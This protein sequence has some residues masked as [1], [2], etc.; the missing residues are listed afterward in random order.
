MSI[1]K[2]L[3]RTNIS[4][5]SFRP[6]LPIRLN[7]TR[8]LILGLAAQSVISEFAGLA[9]AYVPP[10]LYET[11]T[12][13]SGNLT[14]TTSPNA[15]STT[16]GGTGSTAVP[17][18][19]TVAQFDGNSTSTTSVGAA[20]TWGTWSV[21]NSTATDTINSTRPFT[22]YGIT[23]SPAGSDPQIFDGSGD[24]E[25]I[26]IASNNSKAVIYS[27]QAGSIVNG[28]VT[29]ENSQWWIN[30]QT[31][32][33]ATLSFSTHSSDN[34]ELALTNG[35]SGTALTLSTTNGN[36]TGGIVINMLVAGAGGSI[37]KTN[38]GTSLIE[39]TQGASAGV[40]TYS[41]GTTVGQ[42]TLNAGST[43][44][45]GTGAV[46]VDPAA[47]PGGAVN[48]GNAILNLTATNA[49]GAAADVTVNNY[50]A[51]PISANG[52]INLSAAQAFGSLAG[53]GSVTLG[54]NALTIGSSINSTSANFSGS[55]SSTTG[56]SV[57]YQGQ[58][59][60]TWTVAGVA[61]N[62]NGNTSIESG[63]YSL[64]GSLTS[65]ADSVVVGST[66]ASATPTLTGSGGI[67]GSVTIEGTAQDGGS[68]V[69]SSGALAQLASDKLSMGNLN[70][71]GGSSVTFN[72]LSVSSAAFDSAG[73]TLATTGSTALS[74][75]AFSGLIAGTTYELFQYSGNLTS[76]TPL[77]SEFS[78]PAAPAGET[79][80]LSSTQAT[81]GFIDLTVTAVPEPASVGLL[82]IGVMGGLAR[83]RRARA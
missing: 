16:S 19:L 30:N 82:S 1:K 64:T 11:K 68:G 52:T 10:I 34:G 65:S 9:R 7:R 31:N 50:S 47:N 39:N 60:T 44:A 71:D 76:S 29:I 41:G 8:L 51:S 73:L 54:A 70:L 5:N 36:T 79:Y 69:Q 53:S 26:Y 49:V 72:S 24:V 2:R 13:G 33:A 17:G 6:A 62:Y 67:A 57:V 4:R 15:W 66:T 25:G 38:T 43:G 56:G 77:A 78:L 42:G 46:D 18:S 27:D 48:G 81:N 59:A 21:T 83:R 22:L 74:G 20:A 32:I 14:S 35:T 55:I 75:S 63:T 40:N 45:L 12:T 58:S 80:L 28:T 23:A 3:A 61:N 37:V